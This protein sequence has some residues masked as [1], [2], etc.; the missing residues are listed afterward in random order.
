M[1]TPTLFTGILGALAA[2]AVVLFVIAQSIVEH[3]PKYDDPLVASA[4]EGRIEPLG[5][6]RTS[7]DPAPL[8]AV[9]V[10]ADADA[11]VLSGKDVYDAVCQVCHTTGVLNAPVLGDATTWGDRVSKGKETLYTNSINGINQMPPKGGRPDYTDEQVKL[12]VDYML[13]QL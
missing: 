12:A 4:I 10:A 1:S 9:A 13:E 6:I 7:D 2:M 3:D 11:P 5:R 8:I